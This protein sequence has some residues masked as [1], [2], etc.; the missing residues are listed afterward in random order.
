MS[1]DLRVALRIQTDSGNSRREVNALE[2]D[3]R[4]AGK[5]GAKALADETNKAGAALNRTAQAG[6][7][8]YKIIRQVMR[9]SATQGSAV[10]RQ[11]LQLTQAEFKKLG[12]SGRQAAR[13][14][15]SELV[16]TDREGVQALARSVDKADASFRRLAQN[17][18]NRL[19]ALKSLAAGVRSEFDRL[20]S[21]GSSVNG[22]L[23]GLGVGLAVGQ[24]F[25]GSAQLDRA[26]IRT[27]QTAGMSI[28]QMDEWRGEGFRI[29]KQYGVD[30]D[31]VDQGFNTL[32]ASGVNYNAAKLAADAIGRTTAITGA[33]SGVLGKAVVAGASA[34]NVDLNKEGAALD[35]LQ[36]MTV[37]GRL[38]NAEL[39]NLADIFPKIGGAAASAGMNI[40]QALA[41]TETLSTVEM[42]PDR[43]GTLAEST[44]R[45]FSNK[46]YR[47][48]VTKS[49]G[50]QFFNKDGSS[51]NPE[52]V[53]S[54]L[55]RKYDGM[56]TDQA[57]AKF[58]G[59]VFKGMDQ[60]T[61]RGWRIMLSGNRLDTFKEQGKA[62]GKAAS[63]GQDDLKENTDSATGSAARVRATLREAM[64]RMSRPV[65]KA[66]ADAGTYL[67]DD[68]KLSG[69]DLLAGGLA[70]GVGTY[71]AGRGAKAGV[72]KLLNKFLGGPETLKNVAVGK[73]LEEATGVT[74]V[75]VT[76]WPADL[77]GGSLP[78]LPPGG[79]P[80]A[81]PGGFVAPWLA[82]AALA[83]AT[84]QLGGDSVSTD[85][86]RLTSVTNSKTLSEGQRR[87]LTAFYQNRMGLADQAPAGLSY[88]ARENWLSSNAMRLAQEQ[89]GY[90]ANGGTVAGGNA[91][92]A[93]VA[94]RLTTAALTPPGQS[95]G[96]GAAEARLAALLSKP[97]VVEVKTDSRMI[98]AEVERRTDIQMRRG[99]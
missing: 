77:S 3:L 14:A 67:L 16:K 51:R 85:E 81:G 66:L 70:A 94:S 95:A 91:W 20:K 42:Q 21:F 84:A 33:D 26:L 73:A 93:G 97:L 1:S 41:F 4:Q 99:N 36:K 40:Q 29:A 23:A 9:D 82:P 17:G 28:A 56:A 54:D 22:R 63:V 45:V 90:T 32:I 98:T 64:D 80:K 83:L 5:Q 10:F 30:R 49:T 47:D 65:N 27:R 61:V 13:D 24:Q 12:D 11:D 58:M 92:A 44:L 88:G 69:G 2:R 19:R 68:L 35:L 15:K 8:S 96:P 89:T 78:G 48:N 46:Q 31:S 52:D 71:Y 37:A 57:R 72:G 7:A 34:F 86:A 62:V 60:D 74:S 38:G 39:E 18:G 25:S 75:F 43:L 79:K 76:N 50:V 55:K 53:F 87:Y 59:V 6:T